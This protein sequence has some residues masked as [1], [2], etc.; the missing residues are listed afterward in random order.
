MPT[1]PYCSTVLFNKLALSVEFGA[2][3]TQIAEANKQNAGKGHYRS[4]K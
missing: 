2:S 4:L 1:Q 3:V